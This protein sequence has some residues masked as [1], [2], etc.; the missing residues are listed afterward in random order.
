MLTRYRTHR[1]V[2]GKTLLVVQIGINRN[3]G[4]NDDIPPSGQNV[5][6]IEWRDA[7]ASDLILSH[8]KD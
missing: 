2:F 1:T 8:N 3:T 5:D 7:E 6:Y 4:D